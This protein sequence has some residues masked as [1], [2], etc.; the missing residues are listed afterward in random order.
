MELAFLTYTLIGC[1]AL[2]LIVSLVV[3]F[4]FTNWLVWIKGNVPMLVAFVGLWLVVT[5]YSLKSYVSV[6][7]SHSV[8]NASVVELTQGEFKLVI[9]NG[10][11]EFELVG[12]GDLF[13]T[14]TELVVPN[15]V[16]QAMGLPVLAVLDSM[17]IETNRF[18]QSVLAD[19]KDSWERSVGIVG[20]FHLTGVDHQAT[21]SRQLPL[22]DGALYSLMLNND[23]LTWVA[24]NS[25]AKKA[26]QL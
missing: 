3:F 24:T 9:D 11:S 12:K 7:P 26:L 1:G 19:R 15:S 20:R 10:V 8:M 2:A 6:S 18:E 13:Q 5:G 23:R 21:L 4:K 14:K 17:V 25:V 22:V 16:W